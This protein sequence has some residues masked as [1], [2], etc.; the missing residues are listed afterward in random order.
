MERVS[1]VCSIA[2]SLVTKHRNN[3]VGISSL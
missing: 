1:F 2:R 3:G